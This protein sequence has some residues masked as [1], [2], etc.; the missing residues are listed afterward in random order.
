[1]DSIHRLL[2]SRHRHYLLTLID[3]YSRWAYARAL[4]AITA[5]A[6]VQVV[7]RARRSAPFAF[8][9]I[10]TDHGSEFSTHFTQ[11][12]A[13]WRIQ[14]RH[15]RV[16]QPNDQAHVE[17]FNRTLQEE[18]RTDLIR[19]QDAPTK[20]NHSLRAY[21]TYYNTERLHLGIAGKTPQEMLEL[22]GRC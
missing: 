9:C 15:G 3:V 22:S 19:Y 20:L 2:P 16:R 14:H 4:P 6:S 13:V 5:P 7:G 8:Q 10:Q 17:R 11:R 12:L 18:L 1:M 21:L